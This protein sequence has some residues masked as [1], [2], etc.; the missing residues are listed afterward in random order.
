MVRVCVLIRVLI[1]FLV[2]GLFLYVFLLGVQAATLAYGA[3]LGFEL[4]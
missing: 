4:V 2:S 1:C 3:W